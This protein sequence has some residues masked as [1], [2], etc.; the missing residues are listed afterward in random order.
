MNLCFGARALCDKSDSQGPMPSGLNYRMYWRDWVNNCPCLVPSEFGKPLQPNRLLPV[1][2]DSWRIVTGVDV[3]NVERME[4]IRHADMVL[5]LLDSDIYCS[6][7]TRSDSLRTGVLYLV[8]KGKLLHGRVAYSLVRNIF[9]R[10]W[11]TN[12][13]FHLRC[14]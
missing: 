4:R 8:L 5:V 10:S 3:P 12:G 14:R 2:N 13:S 1:V 11:R 9:L 6:H 7:T